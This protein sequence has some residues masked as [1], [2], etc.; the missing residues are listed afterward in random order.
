M[1]CFQA[2]LSVSTCGTASGGE[3]GEY[4]D[5][6]QAHGKFVQVE[7]NRPISVYRFP[8]RALTLCPQLCLGI[9]PGA[10]FP[11]QSADA[12]SAPLYP[13]WAFHPGD[14]PKSTH[15]TRDGTN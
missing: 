7:T 2:V 6:V 9:Q 14:I 15:C 11:A 5:H 1:N 3:R 4:H 10:R 8:H 13:I 12:L